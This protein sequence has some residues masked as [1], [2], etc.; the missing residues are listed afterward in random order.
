MSRLVRTARSFPGW[1]GNIRAGGKRA[2]SAC[3]VRVTILKAVV[4][5]CLPASASSSPTP[6]S[7]VH[8]PNADILQLQ[9]TLAARGFRVGPIDGLDGPRTRAALRA[10]QQSA[11]LPQSLGSQASDPAPWHA[12]GPVLARYVVTTGDVDAL[13]TVPSTWLGK[14]QATRLPHETLLEA[15]AERSSAHPKLLLQLNPRISWKQVS[16]GTE[17]VLPRF[18]DPPI[19]PIARVS[20]NL[21]TCTL[22]AR[23]A[24][25]H[26]VLMA[27]CSIGRGTSSRPVGAFRVVS[28]VQDPSYTFDPA[29][30]PESSE[31]RSL[32]RKLLLPPG[33]NNP[34]GVAW[35]GLNRHGIGIHG[36]PSPETVGRP[37]SHGCFRLA[38][39][40]ASYLAKVSWPGLPVEV[41]D[42]D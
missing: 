12:A 8:P 15:M 10:F 25:G 26:I 7:P 37:E 1:G 31:A 22:V 3:G 28:I 30:F 9:V 19:R 35:I 29:R 14:S 36:S 18:R 39:W 6:A 34:V 13:G 21:K 41:G 5:G 17:L 20:I 33:P 11:S 27:P 38:N 2:G 42:H 23:D 24:S 4:I 16:P 40:D 32:D